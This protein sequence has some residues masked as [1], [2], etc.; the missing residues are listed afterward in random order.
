MEIV[1]P[2]TPGQVRGNRTNFGSSR[3]N[4]QILCCLFIVVEAKVLSFVDAFASFSVL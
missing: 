1:G 3:R 4:L 2:V